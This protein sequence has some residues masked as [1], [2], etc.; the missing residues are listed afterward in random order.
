MSPSRFVNLLCGGIGILLDGNIGQEGYIGGVHGSFCIT[1]IHSVKVAPSFES[2]PC[3][4][5]QLLLLPNESTT[6]N[7]LNKSAN[8]DMKNLL[9][10]NLLQYGGMVHIIITPFGVN[11]ALFCVN[12]RHPCYRRHHPSV[13]RQFYVYGTL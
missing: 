6:E 4:S 1:Q 12:G 2:L 11:R 10:S 13:V 9:F 5:F 8:Y 7:L 3:L